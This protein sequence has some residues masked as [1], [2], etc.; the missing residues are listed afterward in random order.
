MAGMITSSRPVD[1]DIAAVR[2]FMLARSWIGA[3]DFETA[4]DRA[5]RLQLA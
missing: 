5:R 3:Q 4:I 1:D 2:A